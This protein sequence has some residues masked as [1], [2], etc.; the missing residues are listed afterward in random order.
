MARKE[1]NLEIDGEGKPIGLLFRFPYSR[2]DFSDDN[3]FLE[4]VNDYSDEYNR[5]GKGLRPG[6]PHPMKYEE[7]EQS[8]RYQSD[9]R[10]WENTVSQDAVLKAHKPPPQPGPVDLD[11]LALTSKNKKDRLT[12]AE[13]LRTKQFVADQLKTAI[14]KDASGD[15]TGARVARERAS[16]MSREID[17]VRK[18]SPYSFVEEAEKGLVENAIVELEKATNLSPSEVAQNIEYLQGLVSGLNACNDAEF[19]YL[20]NKASGYDTKRNGE[21]KIIKVDHEGHRACDIA[22]SAENHRMEPLDFLLTMGCGKTAPE[23][24]EAPVP[25][26]EDS[27]GYYDKMTQKEFERTRE[28]EGASKL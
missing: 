27:S 11:F 1:S 22:R 10:I 17:K 20:I 13:Q 25:P 24:E 3:S 23:E 8:S 15:L 5:I 9:L 16:M 6:E 14:L 26:E 18:E 21:L 7:G 19:S 28:D 4:Y 12:G 2:N